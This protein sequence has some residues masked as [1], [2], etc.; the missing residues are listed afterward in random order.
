[1]N[2]IILEI[3]LSAV[4]IVASASIALLIYIGITK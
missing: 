2:Q 1:M 3:L 4:G